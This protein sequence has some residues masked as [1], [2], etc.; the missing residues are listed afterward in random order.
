MGV[1]LVFGLLLVVAVLIS[2]RARTTVLSTSALFLL[3]GVAL[4][5]IGVGWVHIDSAGELVRTSAAVAL[6]TILIVDGAQLSI[7]EI[8]SAWRLPGRALLLGQPLTIA[9][10][11]AGAHWLLGVP[12]VE[13]LLVGAVLSPTDPIITR[14]ILV[15]RAVPLR[16]RR[17]LGVEAGLNDGLALPL[18]VLL[19][20]IASHHEVRIVVA[21]ADIVGGIVIG[22]AV[23]LVMLRLE[24]V[25]WFAVSDVY[26]PIAGIAAACTVFGLCGVTGANAFLAAYSAGVVLAT[27]GPEF[28]D[29]I[30][31][32]GE[33]F[34]EVVKLAVLFVFGASLTL[35]LE[36]PALLFTAFALLAARPIALVLAFVG[37]GLGR[38]ELLA[39][40]WFGP[41]GF[42]SL[43]YAVLVLQAGIPHGPELFRVIGLVIA[44]SV[45]AHSSTDSLVARAF[46]SKSAEDE[47]TS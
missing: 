8:A 11:A 39:A 41:K 9:I 40:S 25:R 27:Y 14:S 10:T 20:A 3:A 21:I 18:V 13:A 34:S 2:E 33:P 47:P 28:A 38:K 37:G 31:K 42:S 35:A 29:E 26:R 30:V 5:N 43:L 16:L 15:N 36:P 46:E 7:Q 17:L 22:A 1:V 45:L 32:I 4:G 44:V 19:A 6:V 23:P 24:R 12:W